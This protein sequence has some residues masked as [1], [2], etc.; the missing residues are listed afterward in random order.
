MYIC[1]FISNI[2]AGAIWYSLY[3]KIHSWN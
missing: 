1:F 2:L 3:N